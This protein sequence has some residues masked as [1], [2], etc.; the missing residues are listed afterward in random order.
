MRQ[1]RRQIAEGPSHQLALRNV[2]AHAQ[3]TRTFRRSLFGFAIA[4]LVASA[5]CAGPHYGSHTG[6]TVAHLL[7]FDSGCSCGDACNC[8][9]CTVDDCANG[10]PDGCAISDSGGACCESEGCN[11]G[12]DDGRTNLPACN[13]FKRVAAIPCETVANA[14]S[15]CTPHACPG[16]PD[17]PPPG[18]FH[19]VPTRPVFSPRFEPMPYGQGEFESVTPQY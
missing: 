8:G 15:C 10:P 14:T 16:P 12:H 5:G 7:G 1:L 18:R 2:S 17:V 13:A 9:D 3:P 19:P 11:N 6:A 4:T